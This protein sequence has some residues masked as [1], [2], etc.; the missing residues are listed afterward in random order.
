VILQSASLKAKE[1]GYVNKEINLAIERQSYYRAPRIFVIPTV[2][3]S[4]DSNLVAL[5]KIQFIDLSVS[6]GVN[7]L[8][9]TIRRDLDAASRAR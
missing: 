4:P 2:I 8:V 9:K 6:E 7:D 3:D 1:V 5:E